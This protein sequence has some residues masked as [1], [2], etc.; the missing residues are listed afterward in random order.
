MILEAYSVMDKAVNAF[1][2]PFFC[3]SKGE[4]IRSF[5]QAVNEP[6]HQFN[7]H[8]ADYVLFY[9]GQWNDLS[10]TFDAAEPA[11]IIAGNE[12]LANDD[13]VLSPSAAAQAVN[14][15]RKMPM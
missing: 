6:G 3:R 5:G 15:S 9:V 8:Y 4:A 11:R 10:G 12:V 1:L 2:Q 13:V 14:G 7:K